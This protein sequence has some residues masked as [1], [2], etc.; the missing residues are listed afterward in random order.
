VTCIV[1]LVADQRVYIGADSAGVD[2]GRYAMM[3]RADRKVF[4]NGPFLMGFTSSFRMGQLLAHALQPPKPREG[5][6]IFA[7]MVTDFVNAVRD[8]LKTGG[9]AR[10]TNEE[11]TGG[12]FLVGFRGRLFRIEGDYQVGECPRAYDAV[13]CGDLIALGALRAMDRD[14]SLSPSGRVM[15]ALEAAEDYSAGVRGPFHIECLEAS[16]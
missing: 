5:A 7:F 6:D 15:T 11:E 14:T 1:G 8:C 2:G 4:R 13:G 9:Y 12:T 16:P 3:L 10:K